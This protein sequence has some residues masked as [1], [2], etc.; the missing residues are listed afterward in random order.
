MLNDAGHSDGPIGQDLSLPP[1]RSSQGVTSTSHANPAI[2]AVV[3]PRRKDDHQT[4]QVIVPVRDRRAGPTPSMYLRLY[5]TDTLEAAGRPMA[6]FGRLIDEHSLAA[7]PHPP[8]TARPRRGHAESPPLGLV[9]PKA[10]LPSIRCVP[11]R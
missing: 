10:A 11:R 6:L 4:V 2:S 9:H 3:F 7:L 8:E 1:P 5:L